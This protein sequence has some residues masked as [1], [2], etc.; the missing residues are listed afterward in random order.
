MNPIPT[1]SS[2]M[3][4]IR[5]PNPTQHASPAGI[6][7]STNVNNQCYSGSGRITIGTPNRSIFVEGQVGG[8]WSGRPS[9]GGMVGGTIR[10]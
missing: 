6:S 9:F 7:G 4:T 5:I 2:P 1:F 8:G 10:F 3:Q